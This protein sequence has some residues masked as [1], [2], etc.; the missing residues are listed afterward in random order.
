MCVYVYTYVCVCVYI[1]ALSV[2]GFGLNTGRVYTGSGKIRVGCISG[3]GKIQVE[4]ISIL[5]VLDQPN[6]LKAPFLWLFLFLSKLKKTQHI[7]FLKLFVFN[8]KTFEL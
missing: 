8:E 6:G 5:R 7:Y 4:C 3:L 1:L 2:R